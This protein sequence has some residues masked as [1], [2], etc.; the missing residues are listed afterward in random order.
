MEEMNHDC[1]GI[2]RDLEIAGLLK[3][4]PGCCVEM[5]SLER[6]ESEQVHAEI[7]PDV[8]WHRAVGSNWTLDGARRRKSHSSSHCP[9]NKLRNLYLSVSILFKAYVV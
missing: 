1:Y 9:K 2:A 3:A 8:R 5:R 6:E 7:P 4:S